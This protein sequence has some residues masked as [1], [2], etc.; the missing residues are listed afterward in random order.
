MI[1]S[2]AIDVGRRLD[3]GTWLYESIRRVEVVFS[4]NAH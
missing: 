1:M 4:G 2:T 3:G